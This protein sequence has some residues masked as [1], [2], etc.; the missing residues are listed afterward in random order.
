MVEPSYVRAVQSGAIVILDTSVTFFSAAALITNSKKDTHTIL[1]V[2]FFYRY[3]THELAGD[4][5]L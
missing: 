3:D 2:C 4:M 1:F 5:T